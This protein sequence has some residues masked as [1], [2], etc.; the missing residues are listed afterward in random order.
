MQSGEAIVS[1]HWGRLYDRALYSYF[2]KNNGH[3]ER[4]GLP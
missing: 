1:G 2:H 4:I 3:K